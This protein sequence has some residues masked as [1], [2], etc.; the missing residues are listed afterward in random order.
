MKR[1]IIRDQ[2]FLQRVCKEAT[3]EDRHI[4]QD[5]ID[6]LQYYRIQFEGLI[7]IAANMIGEAKRIIVFY[8]S[9]QKIILM[10]NPVIKSHSKA[11]RTSQESCASVPGIRTVERYET[12][13][14]SY[15]DEHFKH[16]QKTFTGI[17]SFAVQHEIDHLDGKLV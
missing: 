15:Y 9:H 16:R 10:Y 1:E 4:G 8:D 2:F 12:I 5:M 13:K 7:G 17:Q 14:V 3:K 11:T 6:T